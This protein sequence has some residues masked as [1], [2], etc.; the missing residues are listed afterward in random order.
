MRAHIAGTASYDWWYWYFVSTL[1]LLTYFVVTGHK[2]THMSK[3]TLLIWSRVCA[4]F[5]GAQSP[6]LLCT[7]L[8]GP[9]GAALLTCATEKLASSSTV[10]TQLLCSVD[11]ELFIWRRAP[12][13]CCAAVRLSAAVGHD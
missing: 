3:H 11:H 9:M 1:Y 4:G 5:A 13:R 12:S 8:D 10:G 7:D 6:D 2:D